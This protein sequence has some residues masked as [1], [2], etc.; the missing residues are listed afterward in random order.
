M[1]KKN[2]IVFVFI[3]LLSLGVFSL[4]GCEKNETKAK[5]SDI[6]MVNPNG[7][8][9][10]KGILLDITYGDMILLDEYIEYVDEEY[11][12]IA[13]DADGIETDLTYYPAW[14]PTHP[15]K[16]TITYTILEGEN[17][18]SNSFELTV[19][20]KKIAVELNF[21][22]PYFVNGESIDFE[23]Y[24]DSLNINVDSYYDYE[25]VMEYIEHNGE[26]T[27]IE[28][29]ATSYTFNEGGIYTVHFYIKSLDGQVKNYKEDITVYAWNSE[30]YDWMKENNV[31]AGINIDEDVDRT[32][33]NVNCTID[34]K[35]KDKL[36][37]Y[38][39]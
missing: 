12:I 21:R 8:K 27:D 22:S 9:F 5:K 34:T 26:R 37:I 31:Y 23:S 29:N 25:V 14:T 36:I 18:G 35:F 13:K 4:V 11:T 1:K 39:N 3:F 30:F 6:S 38:P 24:F 7:P 10:L 20:P 28:K 15:G 33:I 32:L 19:S 16:Y 17:K 2:F